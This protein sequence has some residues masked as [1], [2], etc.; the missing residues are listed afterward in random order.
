MAHARASHGV[1]GG[2]KI[3]IFWRFS[4]V[5]DPI[6]GDPSRF[7][8]ASASGAITGY[9]GQ[10]VTG[11]L[12]AADAFC[13]PDH[14][15]PVTGSRLPVRRSRPAVRGLVCLGHGARGMARLV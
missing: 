1:G 10:P 3:V 4:A 11:S 2:A 7:F 12:P 6:S 13:P 14:G 5:F 9:H 15:Q 8:T